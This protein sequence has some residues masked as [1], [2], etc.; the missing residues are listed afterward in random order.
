M[1]R[2]TMRHLSQLRDVD[3]EII[4]LRRA[5]A[6]TSWDARRLADHTAQGAIGTCFATIL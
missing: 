5:L 4:E 1:S 2:V 6:S 3:A